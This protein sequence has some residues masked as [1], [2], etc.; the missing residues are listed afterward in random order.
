[1][2]PR[3]FT[4]NARYAKLRREV[5]KIHFN[6]SNLAW[7]GVPNLRLLGS[8]TDLLAHRACQE[9]IVRKVLVE[10]FW[11]TGNQPD[12]LALNIQPI[13]RNICDAAK[14][15]WTLFGQRRY[16]VAFVHEESGIKWL[17]K[18][19][20]CCRFEFL[21][22]ALFLEVGKRKTQ[23]FP[24]I[25]IPCAGQRGAARNAEKFAEFMPD[26]FHWRNVP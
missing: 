13:A 23:V 17:D 7:R 19:L 14:Q 24:A 4:H 2:T 5:R 18:E 6:I 22:P 25:R 26:D 9:K 10:H 20:S 3:R 1:M 8:R 11:V 15:P 16:Q 12:V 21:E